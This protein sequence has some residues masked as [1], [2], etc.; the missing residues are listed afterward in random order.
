MNIQQ[1][2]QQIITDAI[3]TEFGQGAF[4]KVKADPEA[5]SELLTFIV[6]HPRN[7]SSMREG[8]YHA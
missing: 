4:E 5:V 2:N 3:N 8:V 1:T 7:E 6:S